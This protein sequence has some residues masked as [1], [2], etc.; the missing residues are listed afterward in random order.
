MPAYNAVGTIS[1]AIDS[2]ISQTYRN[3]ELLIIDDCSIDRTCDVIQQY[4]IRESRIK[5][6]KIHQNHGV[7]N[8]RNVGLNNVKGDYVAFLDS[9]DYWHPN[10][11]EKQILY[12]NQY[13]VDLVFSEYYRFN[14]SGI[15]KKIFIPKKTI[16][17]KDLLKGNCIGNLTGI[18]D[19]KKHGEIR[20]KKVGAEDYLFWLE[21]FSKPG[22]K[23]VGVPEPLAYYRVSENGD[24][25]S[26]N[27]FRAGKWTWEIYFSHLNLSFFKS[28]FYFMLYVYRAFKN[29]V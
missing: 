6:I 21:V 10:K 9:D 25:L 13:G 1:I 8:A 17:F 7:A 23:G 15:I 18:Y 2:I 24:S 28:L 27:K 12:F 11:L 5:L 26:A 29:R 14:E 22:V 3:W 19:F 20:Q 16:Q 4:L